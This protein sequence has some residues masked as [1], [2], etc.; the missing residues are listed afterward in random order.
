MEFKTATLELGRSTP[1]TAKERAEARDGIA[2]C[3]AEW[4]GER[5]F[6][7]SDDHIRAGRSRYWRAGYEIRHLE[8]CVHLVTHADLADIA[9][10]EGE[11]GA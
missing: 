6:T 2:T 1:R 10:W 5:E 7:T 8:L 4:R 11:G 9:R 3:E